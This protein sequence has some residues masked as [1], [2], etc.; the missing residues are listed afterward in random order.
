[1]ATK[2][3][4]VLGPDY[5]LVRTRTAILLAIVAAN[6][7]RRVLVT[8]S[9]DSLSG[10]ALSLPA[11]LAEPE[12]PNRFTIA[13]IPQES[14]QIIL[15]GPDERDAGQ[16]TEKFAADCDLVICCCEDDRRVPA[17]TDAKV[18]V[19]GYDGLMLEEAAQI[20]K[21]HPDAA[22]VAAT[23]LPNDFSRKFCLVRAAA[24]LP[25]ISRAA[26]CLPTAA[27]RELL[28]ASV[29]DSPGLWHDSQL[30]LESVFPDEK[31]ALGKTVRYGR[32][33]MRAGQHDQQEI[34]DQEIAVPEKPSAA[35]PAAAEQP[36]MQDDPSVPAARQAEAADQRL[37]EDEQEA[38]RP[39][40]G[41]KSAGD[42]TGDRA[43]ADAEPEKQETAAGQRQEAPADEVKA[44]AAAEAAAEDKDAATAAGQR[45]EAPADEVKA[46]AA[47][48][49]TA[50]DKDAAATAEPGSEAVAA[51]QKESDAEGKRSKDEQDSG[52][53]APKITIRTDVAEN[54]DER[55]SLR[56]SMD[57]PNITIGLIDYPSASKMF[58]PNALLE[59]Q[60]ATAQNKMNVKVPYAPNSDN[61]TK[62]FGELISAVKRIPDGS[63][64]QDRRICCGYLALQWARQARQLKMY[65]LEKSLR[66]V[67]NGPVLPGRQA[68]P[69]PVA[70][71]GPVAGGNP[72]GRG[73]A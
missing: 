30:L 67:C 49:A 22:I 8:E 20:H 73:Q 52:F 71:G 12:S 61:L 62:G 34:P 31:I 40:A 42:E 58:V 37:Q 66:R 2:L 63:Y 25:Q 5:C 18:L 68:Q 50:E 10:L 46:A 54:E 4:S 64:G 53:Q 35:A 23:A 26:A 29:E 69:V 57:R 38:G 7:G 1:M 47:A 19:T 13:G 36:A 56:Q 11:N 41:Q 33:I 28:P 45:Q 60:V 14:L 51:V 39:A 27:G 32:Q 70:A 3:L 43:A 21:R 72:H 44:A 15:P 65:V 48:E 16:V 59:K 17:A 24:I 6:C 55:R 9:Q